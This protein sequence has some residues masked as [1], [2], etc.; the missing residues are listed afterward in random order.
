ML[1][2]IFTNKNLISLPLRCDSKLKICVLE[3]KDGSTKALML[4]SSCELIL[5]SPREI[6]NSIAML[7]PASFV[8]KKTSDQNSIGCKSV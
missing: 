1:L 3:I 2:K 4:S 5:K 6:I 7:S 8:C